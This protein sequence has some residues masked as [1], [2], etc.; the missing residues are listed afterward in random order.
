MEITIRRYE[1]VQ[2]LYA[3]YELFKLRIIFLSI[4]KVSC[5]FVLNHK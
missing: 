2:N 1:S 5:I 4:D 3:V